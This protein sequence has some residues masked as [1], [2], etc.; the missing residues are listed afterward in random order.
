VEVDEA[1]FCHTT[2][3]GVKCDVFV[4]GFYERD[5]KDVRAF[6]INDK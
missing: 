5:T 3:N 6:M 2:R 4:L 1:K